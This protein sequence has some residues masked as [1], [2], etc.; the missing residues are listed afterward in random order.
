MECLESDK[1]LL[2]NSDTE[3]TVQTFPAA[4]KVNNNLGTQPT[5]ADVT[6]YPILNTEYATRT[7]G[8]QKIRTIEISHVI[9]RARYYSKNAQ[10]CRGRFS[11]IADTTGA[12]QAAGYWVYDGPHNGQIEVAE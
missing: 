11:S 6:L 4:T 1:P 2:P 10:C 8:V 9:Y 3:E 5:P 12:I 7:A